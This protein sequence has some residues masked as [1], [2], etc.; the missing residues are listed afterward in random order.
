MHPHDFV[1]PRSSAFI[2]TVRTEP[3]SHLAETM[4]GLWWA[5]PHID[6]TVYLQ[7][8]YPLISEGM[9]SA[10]YTTPASAS[11][12]SASD[13]M[14][15]CLAIILASP[16]SVF[17]LLATDAIAHVPTLAP[18]DSAIVAPRLILAHAVLYLAPRMSHH[19][20]RD[21]TSPSQEIAMLFL[22]F[23]TCST[24][25]DHAQL[26]GAFMASQSS[27]SR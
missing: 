12:F 20:R 23:L 27:H 16:A 5:S 18:R 17:G 1:W 4:F 15:K 25:V 26:R 24:P 6:S 14:T 3:Q 19:S 7:K 13:D 8:R 22:L 11:L 2:D 10:V 21:L 9:F